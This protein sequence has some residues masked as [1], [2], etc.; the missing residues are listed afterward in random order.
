M[1]KRPPERPPAAD[2][3]PS[4]LEKYP[5]HG[6]PP[7]LGLGLLNEATLRLEP[8]RSVAEYRAGS[9]L[10]YRVTGSFD[11]AEGDTACAATAS[12]WTIEEHFDGR[13]W[14]TTDGYESL[15]QAFYHHIGGH[16]PTENPRLVGLF[17]LLTAQF[18]IALR[19]RAQTSFVMFPAG[20][21]YA[22]RIPV[23]EK[24]LENFQRFAAAE[25]DAADV[26]PP[27]VAK[28]QSAAI[29]TLTTSCSVQ[30]ERSTIVDVSVPLYRLVETLRRLREAGAD[31]GPIHLR[32]EVIY[33]HERARKYCQIHPGKIARDIVTYTVLPIDDDAPPLEDLKDAFSDQ[34]FEIFALVHEALHA[35]PPHDDPLGN[36]YEE[37][38]K[39]TN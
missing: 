37:G 25:P 31:A 38:K 19:I 24:T 12:L 16:V 33:G 15:P 27:T 5:P 17:D 22:I 3:G 35:Q 20:Y 10:V 7:Y 30:V 1:T 13:P 21:V 9:D 14:R 18:Q 28:P 32:P 11:P 36:I 26:P 4:L 29:L 34:S 39:S 23:T 6:F 2:W 8:G